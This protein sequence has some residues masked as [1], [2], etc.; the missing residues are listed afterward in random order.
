M[1]TKA[2]V[3]T[4]S[5]SLESFPAVVGPVFWK[6]QSIEDASGEGQS[7]GCRPAKVEVVLEGFPAEPRLQDNC[8]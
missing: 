3:H 1:E 5:P 8:P 2:R 6:G 4:P 7:R